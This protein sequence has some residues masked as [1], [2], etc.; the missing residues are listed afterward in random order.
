MKVRESQI[1]EE[2]GK[3]KNINDKESK[4]EKEDTEEEVC[5]TSV[6]YLKD[7]GV[8][9]QLRGIESIEKDTRFIEKPRAR[10][11]YGITINK[12][13]EP[14][15]FIPKVNISVWFETEEERDKRFE[16]IMETLVENKFK[17]IDTQKMKLGGML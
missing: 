4:E 10:F 8:V 17:V 13:I 15:K 9:L 5:L 12:G 6:I 2:S 16:K 11:Q 7:F 1:P 3:A 14:T